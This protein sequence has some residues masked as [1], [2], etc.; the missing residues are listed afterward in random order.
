MQLDCLFQ[1]DILIQE[2]DTAIS[3][4]HPDI[5]EEIVVFI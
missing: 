2:L 4:S 3:K 5:A 1:T